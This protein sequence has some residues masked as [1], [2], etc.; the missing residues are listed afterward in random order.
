MKHSR[1]PNDLLMLAPHDQVN[2]SG[3]AID[4]ALNDEY[5]IPQKFEAHPAYLAS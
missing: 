5:L 1:S 2:A 4:K 3:Y